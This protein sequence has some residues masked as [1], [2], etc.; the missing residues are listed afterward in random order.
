MNESWIYPRKTHLF[1]PKYSVV[2]IESPPVDKLTRESWISGVHITNLTLVRNRQDRQ[3]R[4]VAYISLKDLRR[5]AA[6]VWTKCAWWFSND[7]QLPQWMLLPRVITT[8]LAYRVYKM[9][10]SP[11]EEQKGAQRPLTPA[12]S[13]Q[14]E[15]GTSMYKT[16]WWTEYGVR[17][18][19]DSVGV[20]TVDPSFCALLDPDLMASHP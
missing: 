7:H 14:I 12:E 16:S 1:S 13:I 11:R 15:K 19:L 4:E 8:F 3:A 17:C 18:T 6:S 10:P 2:W 5:V 20:H 9:C